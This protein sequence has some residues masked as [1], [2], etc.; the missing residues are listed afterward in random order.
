MSACTGIN[1]AN[2]SRK[3]IAT[4][5]GFFIFDPIY[6]AYDLCHQLF[7]FFKGNQSGQNPEKEIYVK[8]PKFT[9]SYVILFLL[10]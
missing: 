1:V 10:A 4:K 2:A 3:T 5:S 6:K 7:K 8:L 9:E